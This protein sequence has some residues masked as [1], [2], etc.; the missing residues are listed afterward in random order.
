V[1]SSQKECFILDD[2]AYSITVDRRYGNNLLWSQLGKRSCTNEFA[3]RLAMAGIT[4]GIPI[5][6]Q[7]GSVADV[8]TIR[9]YVT[10]SVNVS[11]GYY[12]PHSDDEYVNLEEITKIIKWLR[13]FVNNE[14]ERCQ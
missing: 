10:D 4:V 5:E 7:D 9:E 6:I 13:L 12:N 8:I 14:K 1:N 11:A 2:V 3:G